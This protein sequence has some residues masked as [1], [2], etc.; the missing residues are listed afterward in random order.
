MKKSV[1][2]GITKAV[3][4]EIYQK[5][6]EPQG[7]LGVLAS[8]GQELHSKRPEFNDISKGHKLAHKLLNLIRQDIT[9]MVRA[10]IRRNK[11][12]FNTMLDEFNHHRESLMNFLVMWAQQIHTEHPEV[13]GEM[14][15]VMHEVRR[16]LNEVA[17]QFQYIFL[18]VAQDNEQGGKNY[19]NAYK[20][21]KHMNEILVAMGEAIDGLFE[22]GLKSGFGKKTKK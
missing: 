14:D 15:R 1:L 6:I 4:K 16:H 22:I 3:L 2:K 5:P 8:L 9:E 20:Q 13:V 7:L 17:G 18:S 10:T 12:D 19:I 21:L 11:E